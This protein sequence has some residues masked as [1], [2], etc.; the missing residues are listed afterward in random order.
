VDIY[1]VKSLMTVESQFKN[2][3]KSVPIYTVTQLNEA[4]SGLLGSEFGLVWLRGEV[5]SLTR[6]SS[7]HLYMSLKDER[8]VV[9]AVMFRPRQAY[10]DFM[11]AVGDAVEIQ[12][13]VGLYEPRGD[14]QINIQV[15]RRAGKGTLHEQFERLKQ[16]LQA[17]GLFDLAQKREIA[18]NPRAIGVITS[19][20]AAA[21]HDV[22]TTLARRAP[23]VPIVVYPSLVQG[24]SAPLALRQALAKA[25]E[26]GEVDTLLLVRGGGSLEDLWAF[27]D[28][29]LA[30]D[31]AASEIP[32]VAGVG[33]ESDTTIADFVADLRAPTPTAAAELCCAPRVDLARV[34]SQRSQ[35][36][37]DR[38][39]HV[40]ERL[41]QR[42][43]R[44]ALRL[45]S[46]S[47]RI[48]AGAHQRALLWQR[49]R[50]A[51]P[52]VQKLRGLHEQ[53]VARLVAS[54]QLSV[55]ERRWQ[56]HGVQTQLLALS[57][58]APLGRGFAIVRGPDGK[59]VDDAKRLSTHD[60]IS[61]VFARGSVS[62]NVQQVEL[63][64]QTHPPQTG[65][66]AQ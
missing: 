3:D 23:H 42:V 13:R 18:S 26:R 25:N 11:P 36:L 34:I 59:I 40:L 55:K 60:Q 66:D 37:G 49:L 41:A 21:L 4:V 5:S 64:S 29:N 44:L 16:K 7:G 31:I 10:C 61:V 46:P 58:T 56:L 20:G 27:N 17:E 43:D 12:A 15:L 57:P 38:L 63:D 9:R 62:A 48:A 19:L 47:E 28:E 35:D 30:R 8:C 52:N 6:A 50:H 14:F 51:A 65:L 24:Q 33:H 54:W 45:V 22:L 53:V 1:V 32:V 2:A 39:N